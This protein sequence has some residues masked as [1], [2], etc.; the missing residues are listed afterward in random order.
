[1][2]AS[3]IIV[4]DKEFALALSKHIIDSIPEEKAKA[5]LRQARIA[6]ATQQAGSISVEGIGQR[7]AVMDRRLY[8]RLMQTHSH[9]E[10]WLDDFLYDCPEFRA[11]GYR[12]KRAGKDLRHGITFM[13][14][15]PMGKG[16]QTKA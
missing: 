13:N 7:A 15:I 2:P 14:G 1:M 6:R 16:P 5:V 8:F 10:G 4:P 9:H 11:P 3:E 12:P